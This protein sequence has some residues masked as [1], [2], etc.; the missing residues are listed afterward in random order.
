VTI[1]EHPNVN[2]E[3]TYESRAFSQN[4][5]E[6][7]ILRS[8]VSFLRDKINKI[9][10][11]QQPEEDETSIKR[12]IASLSEYK[13]SL[14]NEKAKTNKIYKILLSD[15]QQFKEDYEHLKSMDKESLEYESRRKALKKIK[16]VLD[17]KIN[18]IN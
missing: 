1:S 8:E 4:Q 11:T 5:D 6:L 13:I 9:E 18:N 17:G 2:F 15:R 3:K 10:R 12:D 14:E 16:A 7:N